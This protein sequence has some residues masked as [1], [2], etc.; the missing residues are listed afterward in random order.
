M[1]SLNSVKNKILEF[2]NK[3]KNK[4]QK[5]TENLRIQ[6]SSNYVS[7]P[8]PPIAIAIDAVIFA[9]SKISHFAI[10]TLFKAF[11]A[12]AKSN[13]KSFA[14]FVRQYLIENC[15]KLLLSLISFLARKFSKKYALEKLKN[16]ISNAVFGDSLLFRI[17][18][19]FS[20]I[21]NIIA[22]ILDIMDGYWDDKM[23][24]KI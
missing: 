12:W 5:I 11:I 8:T 2:I 4:L 9:I 3:I 23:K 6:Y 10:N 15:R 19:A 24:I 17:Y 21:G 16:R 14:K 1:I 18:S 13:K 22:T 7:L 20:S